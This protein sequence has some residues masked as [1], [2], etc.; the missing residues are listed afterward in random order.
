MFG[1]KGAGRGK[2]FGNG[3]W[4]RRKKEKRGGRGKR[5]LGIS[6]RQGKRKTG[7]RGRKAGTAGRRKKGNEKRGDEARQK[8]FD[9]KQNFTY[10]CNVFNNY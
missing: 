9:K 2:I 4:K 10:G 1:R 5:V 7:G 8:I 6:E 3:V